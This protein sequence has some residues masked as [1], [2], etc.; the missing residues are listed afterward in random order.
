MTDPAADEPVSVAP[1]GK[2]WT[3]R[4]VRAGR[5]PDDYAMAH[6]ELAGLV[7]DLE[8]NLDVVAASGI[9]VTSVEASEGPGIRA[10]RNS[11]D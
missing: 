3:V 2:D 11:D 5:R 4:V 8:L 6:R 1:V 10:A 9:T 7:D